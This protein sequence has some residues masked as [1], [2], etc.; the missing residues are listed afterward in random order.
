MHNAALASDHLRVI[1]EPEVTAPQ[2][3]ACL[4]GEGVQTLA[5][6][7][8]SATIEDVFMALSN[9]PAAIATALYQMPLHRQRDGGNPIVYAE[10]AV[11]VAHMELYGA[12][13]KEQPVG[14]LSGC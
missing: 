8:G 9:R 11:D 7:E 3:A 10:L 5:V 4:A 2:L 1:T 6:M 12:D 13:A 14:N